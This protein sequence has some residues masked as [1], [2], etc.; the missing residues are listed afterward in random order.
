MLNNSLLPKLRSG[1][2]VLGCFVRCHDADVTELVSLQGFDFVVLDAEHG[3]LAPR[4][5]SQLIR[6]AE[7]HGVTPI[8]RVPENR[9]AVI[10]RYLDVGAH[11]VMAS[12]VNSAEEAAAAVAATKYPPLGQRGLAAARAADFGQGTTLPEYTALA[13]EQTLVI[14]QVETAQAVQHAAEIAGVEG[15][16]VVFVG[17]SD[18]SQSLGVTGQTDHPRMQEAVEHVRQ[19]VSAAGKTFGLMVSDAA[20]ARH[21]QDRGARFISVSFEV[22]VRAGCQGYLGALRGT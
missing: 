2:T 3:S 17:P 11:G 18:L 15:V 1:T 4:D 21:W 12:M 6:A 9:Q 10:L 7:L 13:N 16:D 19:A 14:A 5:C 8:A 20:A 22:L